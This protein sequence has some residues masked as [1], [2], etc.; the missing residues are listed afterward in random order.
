MT[1]K[2]E[3]LAKPDCMRRGPDSLQR[4]SWY[5]LL[6]TTAPAGLVTHKVHALNL[7]ELA[8]LLRT[9]LSIADQVTKRHEAADPSM[10]KLSAVH[11]VA[12]V[13][14]LSRHMTSSLLRDTLTPFDALRVGLTAIYLAKGSFCIPRFETL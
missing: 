11:A 12:D 13:N 1:D 8:R 14:P 6:I 9:F 3:L 4:P 7:L 5:F 10:H 2:T